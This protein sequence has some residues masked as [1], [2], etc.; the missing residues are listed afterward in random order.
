[1]NIWEAQN[2]I[3]RQLLTWAGASL[4]AGA[5]LSSFSARF[6][7]GVG[8]QFVGWGA[9]NGLIAFVGDRMSKQ[10]QAKLLPAEAG[11]KEA[12][13]KNNLVR[14]LR[15]NTFLDILYVTFGFLLVFHRRRADRFWAGSGWGIVI[16]GAFLFFFDLVHTL[17]L[18]RR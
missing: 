3:S 8:S 12:Q 4:V 17:R 5:I 11:E 9:I 1:M 15:V 14:L 18:G 13:E 2:K 16:Q 10:R 7:K 6:W